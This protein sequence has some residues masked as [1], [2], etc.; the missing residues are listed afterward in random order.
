MVNKIFISVTNIRGLGAKLLVEKL[1][2]QDLKDFRVI[3]F[4]N[5]KNTLINSNF[6]AFYLNKH[7]LPYEL[8]RI[9]EI[10]T[11]HKIVKKHRYKVFLSL[12]DIPYY[13]IKNQVVLVHNP[14]I[15][16]SFLKLFLEFSLKVIVNKLIFELNSK[17]VDKFIV[18]TNHMF[19]KF[20]EQY[21]NLNKKIIVITF[22]VPIVNY[23]NQLNKR[24]TKNIKFFYPA[25]FYKHKNHKILLSITNEFLEK[26]NFEIVLTIDFDHRYETKFKLIGEIDSNKVKHYY[27]SSHVL[28]FLSLDETFGMPLI[29]AMSFELLIVCPDLPYAREICGEK[30]IYFDPSCVNSLMYAMEEASKLCISN[31]KIDYSEIQK[32]YSKSYSCTLNSMIYGV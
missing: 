20:I 3:V 10:F 26:N 12:G 23:K 16:K 22:P 11:L 4:Q 8:F 7:L 27:A 13:K 29:E 21:P 14:H 25:R 17:F 18:Q 19:N 15:F 30:A 6:K 1:L 31:F 5:L 9:Y 24:H 2:D 32:K 28:L